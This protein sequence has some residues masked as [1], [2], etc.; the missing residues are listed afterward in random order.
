MPEIEVYQNYFKQHGFW[1]EAIQS[2][3][4]KVLSAYDVEWHLMGMDTSTKSKYRLKIHEY[5]S[6]SLPPFPQLKN[7]I[8]YYFNTKPDL[9]I[10]QNPEV[11][12]ELR[13]S[14]QV[15]YLFRDAGI[16]AHFFDLL[17][18]PKKEYDFVYLGA[19]DTTRR[20]HVLLN[21]FCKKLKNHKLLMI[22][23]PPLSLYNKYKF[24]R[25]I[26]FTG[27]QSYS[28]IPS[29]LKTAVYGLNYI[30]PRY[31]YYYQPSLKLI[32][33]CAAGLNVITTSYQ[34]V[35]IFEATNKARFYKVNESLND[36]SFESLVDFDFVIPD[37]RH[38]QWD[39]I[40]NESGILHKIQS[41]L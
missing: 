23:D 14:D 26:Y 30:P 28:E 39:F 10:F 18:T 35:N 21:H 17:Q 8:K 15:P 16:S 40:L 27:K 2:P 20:I 41:M 22:G 31:P 11:K 37:V 25:N 32:E 3:S 24:E 29:L 9:R 33:Y 6:L 36:L 19:M 7:S 1:I 4:A 5:I 12:S 38:L 34:W 13:F